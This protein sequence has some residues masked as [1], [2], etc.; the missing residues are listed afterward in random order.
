MRRPNVKAIARYSW[1]IALVCL[2][3]ACATLPDLS[4]LDTFERPVTPTV[5]N[6]RG[7]VPPK[8]A[9]SLLAKRLRN[10]DTDIK[11]L[12]ALEEAATGSPFNAGNKEKLQFNGPQ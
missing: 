2:L 10:S 11:T 12:A 3:A 6:G 8:Q 5:E 4:R 1:K 7:E 9:H